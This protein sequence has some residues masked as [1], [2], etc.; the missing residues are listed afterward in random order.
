MRRHMRALRSK[1]RVR[2]CGGA[3]AGAL[4]WLSGCGGLLYPES[5]ESS[6]CPPSGNPERAPSNLAGTWSGTV[7]VTY[8][9]GPRHSVNPVKSEEY[10][11]TVTL[12]SFGRPVGIGGLWRSEWPGCIATGARMERITTAS[13][14]P[15]WLP[16]QQDKEIIEVT[17]A[18]F[19]GDHFR[20]VWSRQEGPTMEEVAYYWENRTYQGTLEGDALN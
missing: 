13:K 3:L 2:W 12:D 5:T 18:E 17:E 19:S 6:R 20:I 7:T 14:D 10:E 16:P 4:L 1:S 15:F 9:Y 8:A 11:L